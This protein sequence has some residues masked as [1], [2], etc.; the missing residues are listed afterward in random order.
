VQL[1]QR[2]A[3]DR[4]AIGPEGVHLGRTPSGQC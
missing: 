1:L 3:A 2:N 4:L